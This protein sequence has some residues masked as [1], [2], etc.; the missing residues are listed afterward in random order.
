MKK[1]YGNK[2]LLDT[3][4]NMIRQNKPAHSVIFYGEKGSGRKLMADYYTSQLLCKFP[5]GGKPCGVCSSCRNNGAGV[6]PDVMYVPTEGKLESYSVRTARA[7]IADSGIKPNNDTARKVYIFR[8]CRNMSTQTQN[9]LLKLIEEP[10]EYAYFIFTAESRN[11][12]LPTIISRCICLGVSTCTTDEAVQSLSESGY[13]TD[14]INSATACF[15]GN[16]GRCTDYILNSELKK[17]VDL[18]KRISDSI[19][20]KDE[21]GLNSALYSV[22]SS[23]NDIREV[24]SMLDKLIRD[25][26]ILSR[27]KDARTISC[28]RGAAQQ[29]SGMMTVY[30]AISVH[31]TIEKAWKAVDSN[32]SAPLVFSGLCAEIMTILN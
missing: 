10:P 5:D 14:E 8:D 4:H 16:I 21:Y 24:L 1:I 32:V 28:F 19:I 30:Q 2:Y 26:A 6:H 13:N 31:D 20:R 3:L 11:E 15:H 27:D 9:T 12:F 17:Q 7:V 25:C 18:T 22:G 29:L 23:R